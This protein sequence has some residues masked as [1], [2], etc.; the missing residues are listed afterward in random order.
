MPSL[1]KVRDVERVTMFLGGK[2]RT[3][4]F[5]MNAFAELEKRYGSVQAAMKAL[6]K[7]TIKEVKI[8]LWAGLIHEE[9]I[10]DEHDDT[11][12]IG[13][14]ITPYQVGS[15]IKTPAQMTEAAN[16]LNVAM[17]MKMPDIKDMTPEMLAELRRQGF[18][19]NAQ[20]EVVPIEGFNPEGQDD[21]K[22]V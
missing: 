7:G 8:C 6:A 4:Q 9:A 3:I 17:G 2:E 22:N 19:V 16:K 14:N 5:D 15:W 12:P 10:F 11:E 20:G 21:S 1:D 13:Y 18:E